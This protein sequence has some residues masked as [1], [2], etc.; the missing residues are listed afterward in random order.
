MTPEKQ[1]YRA[2]AATVIKALARRRMAGY[3]C[4]T[5]EEARERLLDLIP[6]GAT[7]SW[8]GSMTLAESGLLDAVKTAPCTV[9]DRA[10]ATSPEEVAAIY[11][12]ALLADVYL[13]STN[14]I[15]RDG[16]L[17]NVDGTGNRLAALIYGPESVIVVTG[18]NKVTENLETARAR[19]RTIA[20]PRNCQR[21]DR[22]TPCA[23]TGFCQE[24]LGDGSVCSSEVITRRSHVRDRIKVILVGEPLGY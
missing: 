19:I 6:E 23:T 2:A 3:Y 5:V 17:V 22:A 14:A 20:A 24:C 11:H 15:T 13:M 21:L 12:Q 1:H 7:V 4:D 10:T 8:G 18:M 9:I 16:Q